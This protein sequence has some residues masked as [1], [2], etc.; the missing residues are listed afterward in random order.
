MEDWR[1]REV[2]EQMVSAGNKSVDSGNNSTAPRKKK[3]EAGG[4]PGRKTPLCSEDPDP[5]RGRRGKIKGTPRSL[6]PPQTPPS[7]P[8]SLT[9]PASLPEAAPDTALLDATRVASQNRS[10]R[11]HPRRTPRL[12]RSGSSTREGTPPPTTTPPW[13]Y[14]ISPRKGRRLPQLRGGPPCLPPPAGGVLGQA[15]RRS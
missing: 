7:R 8:C 12:R 10:R 1:T 6:T 9:P 14:R 4:P 2:P 11:R 15:T 5:M 3:E 13:G